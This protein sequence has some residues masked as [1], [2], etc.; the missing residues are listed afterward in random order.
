MA[1]PVRTL[2]LGAGNPIAGDDGIGI[3]ALERLREQ[4]QF[5]ET[6]ELVDGGTWGM[7][8]L[9]LIE[10]TPRLLVLDAV[11][12]GRPPGELVTV[13]RDALP[14]FL[15]LKLSPH[16]I[17]LREVFALAELRGTLPV[18]LI[19]LGIQPLRVED[20]HVGL[21]PVVAASIDALVDA[22]LAQLREWG[23]VPVRLV[24]A[25]A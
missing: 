25:R 9:P 15:S 23:H 1:E 5:D 22:A 19:V 14:R 7:N 10:D 18:Q 17:D 2:V 4:W 12:A 6:V 20:M 24:A 21:S 16:Q 13:E 3:A 8:L 11:Q